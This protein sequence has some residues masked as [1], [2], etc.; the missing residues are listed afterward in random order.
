V[1]GYT[2][3]LAPGNSLGARM[4]Y[5][6]KNAAYPATNN[7]TLD[8]GTNLAGMTVK[9]RFRIGTDSAA[10]DEGWDIDDVAFEGITNTP[11]PSQV[12]DRTAGCGVTPPIPPKPP[13]PPTP[14]KPPRLP[15]DD[16]PGCCDAGPIRSS[17]LVLALGLL[18]LLLRRRRAR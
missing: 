9:L 17:N 16:Q 10:G 6:G 2:R 11:F 12:E 8:F 4:A 18:G 3:T 14:P 5:A 15:V 7:V 1:P 13:T